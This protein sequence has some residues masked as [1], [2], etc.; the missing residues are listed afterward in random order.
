MVTDNIPP[1]RTK[2]ALVCTGY[3][4]VVACFL[5]IFSQFYIPG[6][7]FT[8]LVMFGDQRSESYL[9]E[10]RAIDHYEMEK[11]FGYDAQHYAQIAMRPVLDDPDLDK[12]VDNLPYRARRIL[13]SWVA[14]GLA[15]GDSALALH[16]F[17]VQNIVCWLILS[18]V[19]LRWFPPTGLHNFIRWSGVLLSF[20]MCFSVRGALV[21]GPSLL[22]IAV[23][24]LL[25]EQ[26]RHGWSTLVMAVAGLGKETNILAA[27]ILADP[28]ARSWRRWLVIGAQGLLVLAPLFLWMTY[29]KL[30]LGSGGGA[31]TRNFDQPLVAYFNKWQAT[32][33]ELGTEGFD[34]VAKWSLLMLIALTM[35]LLYFVIRPQWRQP[36]W[37]VGIS[38][39][40]LMIVLGD[41]VW[42]GYPGAASRV[43]LPMTLAFN[44]LLPRGRAWLLPLIL[45]NL[46]VFTIFDALKPPGGVSYVV[47]GPEELSIEPTTKQPV[48]V[49]FDQ[50]WYQPERSRFEYWRWSGGP[51][52]LT[53]RNPHAFALT[54]EVTFQLRS[55][56]GRTVDL[57]E[58]ENYL[59]VGPVNRYQ[60]PEVMITRYRL[61]PGSTV[62]RFETDQPPALPSG[63]DL[64]E[65][66]FNVRGLTVRILGLA[67]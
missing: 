67:P 18:I 42:E 25:Y 34:S 38:Y 29:L 64:R 15:G 5:W 11:S 48:E 36:W 23:A 45:G 41:A 58:G 59:W 3:V 51:A 28:Q 12:A 35:Q 47:K 49:I 57:K 22:F 4:S 33:A 21:D 46:T 17:S 7:G 24:V 53:L 32:W 37:R 26:G 54:V 63:E 31:G 16:I 50:G 2:V 60:S 9:P 10:L 30:S 62:W 65:V 43:L 44:V 13:L 19:M 1:N 55:N 8:Y 61:E 66:A 39:S 40:V 20:G 56:V 27:S 6:K 14:F 52:Q